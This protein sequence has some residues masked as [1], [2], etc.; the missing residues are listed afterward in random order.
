MPVCKICVQHITKKSPGI[1][2]TGFCQ[3]SYH[4]KCVNLSTEQ[5]QLFK[6]TSGFAW[7][8]SVC[9]LNEDSSHRQSSGVTSFTSSQDGAANV[10]T[11]DKNGEVFNSIKLMRVD[12]QSLNQKQD[13]LL[14]S[15]SFCSDKISDFEKSLGEI[16]GL[17]RSI[18]VLKSENENLKKEVTQL[19][20]KINDLEQ[21]SKRRNI[22][23]QGVPE[24]KNENVEHIV[25][26]II[27]HMGE[28][29][30]GKI[31][32]I[33]RVQAFNSNNKHPR[34]IVVEL[35]S[36]NFKNRIVALSKLQ[37]KKGNPGIAIEGIGEQIFI[38]EHLSTQ[39]KLLFR[40][41]RSWAKTNH[42]KYV[43]IK[44]GCIFVRKDDTA[45]ILRIRDFD[46]LA[47]L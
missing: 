17:I 40:D 12:I 38:N 27:A 32:S 45:R 22:E 14:K 1:E 36:L 28:E 39:N 29:P 3:S 47:S 23:I 8:C 42:Y 16:G 24:A 34:N 10:L 5:F 44:N 31:E 33:H 19:K 21:H 46:T 2:C 37:R 11:H 9:R 41:T 4:L 26:K 35:N 18:E 15:V 13:D 6:S 20:T 25:N 7:K 43:W 30:A